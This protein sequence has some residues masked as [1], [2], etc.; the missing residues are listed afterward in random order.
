MFIIHL[1]ILNLWFADIVK[2]NENIPEEL[3]MLT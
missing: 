3:G 2:E 1:E